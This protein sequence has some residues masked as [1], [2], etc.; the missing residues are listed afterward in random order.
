MIDVASRPGSAEV[1]DIL[2][3]FFIPG[4]A[5]SGT[6][7][8]AHVLAQHPDIF[9]PE[10]K[11]LDF[12]SSW[13]DKMNVRRWPRDYRF[14]RQHLAPGQ[15]AKQLGEASTV[16]FYDPETPSLIAEHIPEAKHV[17]VLRNPIERTYSHYWNQVK[18]GVKLDDFN[19]AILRWKEGDPWFRM[20]VEY[21]F[22]DV[23]LKRYVDCFG[24]DRVAVF[25][26]DDLKKDPKRFFNDICEF[27]D[28]SPMPDSL[29][30]QVR[31]NV[32][33]VPRSAAIAR[34][35]CSDT[36]LHPFRRLPSTVLAPAR[37][38]LRWVRKLNYAQST[39]PRMEAPTRRYLA[40]LFEE[41]VAELSGLI[42]RDLSH[43]LK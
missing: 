15:D 16:Y 23:H 11:E 9:I 31:V 30:L 7:Y 6:S 42:Q 14:Y 40:T 2:P 36:L 41:N 13:L 37:R 39:Y 12:F 34:L 33:G 43:W 38:G 17:V 27:L 20:L 10:L 29:D 21:S 5:K 19:T 18:C 26:Y 1:M 22:Y 24:R 35:L 32:T 3:T 28:V 8:V 25:L 4:A